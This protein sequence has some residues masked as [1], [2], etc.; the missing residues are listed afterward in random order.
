MIEIYNEVI[1]DLLNPTQTQCH[2]R[3]D[4]KSGVHMVGQTEEDAFSVLDVVRLLQ[5]G[6]ANR[7]VGQ[8]NMNRESSRSHCVFSCVIESKVTEGGI[9]NIRHSR[10]NLVDLAGTASVR[11]VVCAPKC[12][13][14]CPLQPSNSNPSAA[15]RAR[16]RDRVSTGSERQ[17]A[18]G[19]AGERRA[20]RSCSRCARPPPW[21]KALIACTEGGF[22]YSCDSTRLQDSLGG[23]SKTVM[24]ANVSPA[25]SN[26]GETLSTQ[27]RQLQV[28]KLLDRHAGFPAWRVPAG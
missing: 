21:R 20:S 18:T 12:S 4:I 15:E 6:T 11:V 8:T 16:V 27:S 10:L 17:K 25:T 22:L 7:H 26:Y 13:Q 1:Y 24:I 19:A 2:I 28:G 23:N 9:T 3:E 14:S 5:T